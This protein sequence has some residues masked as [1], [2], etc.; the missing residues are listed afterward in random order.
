MALPKITTGTM[1]N[2]RNSIDG[3]FATLS[4]TAVGTINWTDTSIPAN[5]TVTKT[6]YLGGSYNNLEIFTNTNDEIRMTNNPTFFHCRYGSNYTDVTFSTTLPA[7]LTA[8]SSWVTATINFNGSSA[9]I[10]FTNLNSA[11][12]EMPIY[13]FIWR[14]YN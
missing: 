7:T 3:N 8:I 14:A 2:V 9:T 12:Q 4:T 1:A 10:T 6:V 13:N 11:S 5:S